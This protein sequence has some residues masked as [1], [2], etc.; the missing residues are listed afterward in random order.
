M[1][2]LVLLTGLVAG[3]PGEAWA[4]ASDEEQTAGPVSLGLLGGSAALGAL[5]GLAIGTGQSRWSVAPLVAP[6]QQYSLNLSH[7]L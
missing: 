7:P 1:A 4:Q 5:V 6:G 3:R 2:V